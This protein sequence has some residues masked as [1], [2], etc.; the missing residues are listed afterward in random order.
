MLPFTCTSIVSNAVSCV[1]HHANTVVCLG[2]GGVLLFLAAAALARA[3]DIPIVFIS[4]YVPSYARGAN[5]ALADAPSSCIIYAVENVY[6]PTE[7]K[8]PI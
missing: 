1:I 4:K 5:A 8:S 3:S 7:Y 6:E 2:G